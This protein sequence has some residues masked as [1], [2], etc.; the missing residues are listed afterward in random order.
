LVLKLEHEHKVF[1]VIDAPV[2]NHFTIFFGGSRFLFSVGDK[3]F[4]GGAKILAIG[5]EAAATCFFRI[6]VKAIW[7]GVRC[8]C[9]PFNL[10][11]AKRKTT[12]RAEVELIMIVVQVTFLWLVVVSVNKK[13]S[14]RFSNA[15][16]KRVIGASEVLLHVQVRTCTYNIY[17]CSNGS[18][19]GYI[20]QSCTFT[21]FL[22]VDY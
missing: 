16:V 9:A 20:V 11:N 4:D 22:S 5:L 18:Q 6:T 19:K 21:I 1:D 13:V 14:L 2:T 7:E 10:K 12:L 8:P 3:V 15:R 17:M